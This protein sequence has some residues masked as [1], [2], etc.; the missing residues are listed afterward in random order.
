MN[1]LKTNYVQQAWQLL[2]YTYGLLPIIA[3]LDKYFHF[4][5]N[6]NQY[7]NP[8]IP[9]LLHMSDVTIMNS[10]GIIEIAAG[11]LVFLRPI[12]GGYLVDWFVCARSLNEST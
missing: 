12:F 4:I 3:G 6:W 1:N 2:Y 8:H 10:V 7:L 5:V 11:I 9:A